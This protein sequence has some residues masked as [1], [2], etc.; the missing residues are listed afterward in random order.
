MKQDSVTFNQKKV[1]NI[2]I[3]YATIKSNN[4]SEYPTFE[5]CLSGAVSLAKNADIGRM[6]NL[7]M[8]LD[9]IDMEF[10]HFLALD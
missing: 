6:D 10:F 4:I 8:G 1:V 7:D 9:L 3:V 2:Y 5:K